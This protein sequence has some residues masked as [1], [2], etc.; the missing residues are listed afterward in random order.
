MSVKPATDIDSIFASASLAE[1]DASDAV[2][3][4]QAKRRA[5]FKSKY[6]GAGSAHHLRREK[7]LENQKQKRLDRFAWSRGLQVEIGSSSTAD[8]HIPKETRGTPSLNFN[9][10]LESTDN[11]AAEKSAA[12][13]EICIAE[14][15]VAPD[16][17]SMDCDALGHPAKRK[18]KKEVRVMKDKLMLSEWM[19][20][21]PVDLQEKWSFVVCP[22]GRRTLVIANR[23]VTSA[24]KRN[25]KLVSRFP[26]HL[27]AGSRKYHG[28]GNNGS[29]I[30]DCILEYN[31][32]T[33]YVIDVMSWNGHDV[34][35][36]ELS[37]RSYWMHSKLAEHEEVL[38][39]A[40]TNPYTFVPMYYNACTPINVANAVA[41]PYPFEIDGLL[42][43]HNECH[44]TPGKT[45]LSLWLEPSMLAEVLG[46]P[47]PPIPPRIKPV[48]AC[49]DEGVFDAAMD[50]GAHVPDD[51]SAPPDVMGDDDMS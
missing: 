16:V 46:I 35:D 5:Q 39:R 14:E 1:R 20:E 11:G 21:V 33:F 10:G 19:R 22:K 38:Q 47:I 49:S 9:L 43:F 50:D 2:K 25:G 44:Y 41:T 3:D 6:G 37:F 32:N 7:M 34:F 31:T 23:G 40:T 24:Y 15:K 36:S 48:L 42:F 30:L 51:A 27:P 28:S 18:H 13:E 8:T 26:S 4:N 12:S 29:C 45:P 17:D